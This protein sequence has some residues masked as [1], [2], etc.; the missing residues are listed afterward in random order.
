MK[1][2]SI[3]TILILFTRCEPIPTQSTAVEKKVIF[4]NYDYDEIVGATQLIPSENGNPSILENPVV[5]L[6]DNQV[7]NLQFD[8]ITEKFEYL[9]VK[10]YHCNKDWTKSMLR[11]MEFLSEINTFRIADYD[12]SLN[13]NPSYINYRFQVPKPTISGNYILSVH[14]RASPNDMLFNR[15]FL[16]VENQSVIE[17]QVRIS[18]TVS[19][20]DENHQIDFSVNYGNI[21]ATNPTQ[22]LSIVL[23][24]NH[25]WQDARRDLKPSLIRPNDNYMEFRLLTLDN[26][27]PG[28]NEFRFFDLRTLSVTG[29]NVRTISKTPSGGIQAQLGLDEKRE[30][31]YTQNLQD[32][33]G[34]FILQNT[35][36][37]D[38]SLNADYANVKFSLKSDKYN[39]KV[40]AIGRFNNWNLSDENIMSYNEANGTYTTSQFLKQGYYEYQYLV[41]ATNTEPYELERSHFQTENDYEI[42][43]Y[44]RKPGNVNDELIGYKKF[45]SRAQ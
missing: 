14:R 31:V 6:N 25:R 21:Q 27:F 20:R 35:D 32:V 18:T 9:A 43:V 29:R 36:P 10:I 11:D 4:D 41:D 34:N 3:L 16:V 22:D 12:F 38:V 42:L 2:L 26:N 45:N 24:Q 7:L 13:T 44:Y 5:E 19:K 39:G 37:G 23:L 15:K 28:W 33:N 30:F 17:Q 40:Y 1:N 8:L